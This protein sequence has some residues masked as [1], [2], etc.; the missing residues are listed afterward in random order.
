MSNDDVKREQLAENMRFYGEMRFKQLTLLSGGMTLLGAGAVQ[1]PDKVLFCAVSVRAVCALAGMLF[2]SILWVMEVRST[3]GFYAAREHAMELWP[4]A[5]DPQGIFRWFSA[6]NAVLLLHLIFYSFWFACAMHW[7]VRCFVLSL[8][9]VWGLL[10]VLFTVVS[11][12]PSWTY[13]GD[14]EP[15]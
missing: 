7:G 11:Y 10:L 12:W 8:L 4:R 15:N 2:T 13:P 6:T 14:K 1:Y 3:L 5:K 9:A